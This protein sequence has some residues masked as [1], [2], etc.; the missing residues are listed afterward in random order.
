MIPI[1]F[2]LLIQMIIWNFLQWLFFVILCFFVW[3]HDYLWSIWWY[4]YGVLVE[5]LWPIIEWIVYILWFIPYYI[6]YFWYYVMKAIWVPL[7]QIC[8]D[9]FTWIEVNILDAILDAVPAPEW[10]PAYGPEFGLAMPILWYWHIEA[11]YAS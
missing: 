4:I 2:L 6:M 10:T 5:I 1:N 3:L 9:I 8:V 7:D 11:H